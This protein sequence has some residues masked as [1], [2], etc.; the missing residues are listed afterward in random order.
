MKKILFAIAFA[1]TLFSCTA[2]TLTETDVEYSLYT[3]G[4]DDGEVD[5]EPGDNN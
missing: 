2:E 5:E 3:S 1:T 4:G